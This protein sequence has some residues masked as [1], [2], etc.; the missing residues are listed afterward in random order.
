MASRATGDDFVGRRAE[1]ALLH[2][3]LREARAGRPA[4]V[5][6]EG[7]PGIG[8]TRLLHRFAAEAPD[9]AMLWASGDETEMPLDYGVAEA[10]GAGVPAGPGGDS[11]SQT[12]GT[13]SA[14]G[15]AVGAALLDALGALQQPRTVAIV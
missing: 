1:L 15:F 5:S 13:A 7:E 12:G 9:V 6:V 3:A 4:I 11:P 8:K 2:R 10:L 14:G